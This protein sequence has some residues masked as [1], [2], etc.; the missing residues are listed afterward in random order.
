MYL[1]EALK[2]CANEN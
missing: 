1:K 2:Y